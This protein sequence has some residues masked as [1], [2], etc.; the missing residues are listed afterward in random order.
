MLTAVNTVKG[1]PRRGMQLLAQ[2]VH[3]SQRRCRPQAAAW[4]QLRTA[5]HACAEAPSILHTHPGVCVRG[6]A[7]MNCLR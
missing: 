1:S 6:A 3:T 2:V 7:P 4:R 5:T